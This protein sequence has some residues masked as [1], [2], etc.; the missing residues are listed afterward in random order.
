MSKVIF[1]YLL[2]M[3]V[4]GSLLFLFVN[5]VNS[6]KKL[7]RTVMG[8]GFTILFFIY[9]I[10]SVFHVSFSLAF[11]Y[12]LVISII[13]I[14][15][16]AFIKFM[17]WFLGKGILAVEKLDKKIEKKYLSKNEYVKKNDYQ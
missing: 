8:V 2:C 7:W 10:V 15:G 14:G 11:K 13:V 5:I 16:L 17:L 9:P 4:Y 12:I 6:E 1:G 3:V